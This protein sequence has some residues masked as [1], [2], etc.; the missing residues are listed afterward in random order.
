LPF[1]TAFIAL[2]SN[3]GD[4]EQNLQSALLALQALGRV[5]RVSSF[6][7]TEPVGPV[8]QPDF[9]NAVAELQTAL[10]P[11]ELLASLLRIEQ[12]HG[13]DRSSAS[14]KGPR[15]L[16]LD[17]L[18]YDDVVM[19][20]A[21]LTLPHPALAERAFVLVPLAEIAPEWLHPVLKASAADLLTRI[22]QFSDVSKRQSPASH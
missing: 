3:I 8:A 11:E 5:G 14:P 15:T 1:S 18:A 9:L 19:D 21:T 4:R 10:P 2:G 17:L 16:D 12:E 7:E 20:S 22:G 6:Y 13:R